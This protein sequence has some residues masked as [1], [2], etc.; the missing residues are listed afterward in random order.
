MSKLTYGP[1]PSRRFGLSLGVDVVP[2]KACTLDCIYCQLG[3]T[4]QLTVERRSF[5]PPEEVVSEVVAAVE[6]G[7]RPDI[8]SFAGSG[9]PTLYQDLGTVARSLREQ[10]GIKLN[11]ITNGTLLWRDDVARDA[12]WFD[13]VAPDLDAADLETFSRI[14]RPHPSLDLEQVLDGI[15]RFSHRHPDKVR[16]EVF[17]VPG[18]ND[19]P[20]ALEAIAKAARRIS[21][22]VVELN[23]AVRP[24]PGRNVAGLGPKDLER[25][26]MLFEPPAVP[27]ASFSS[28]QGGATGAGPSISTVPALA[29]RIL[30]TLRRRPC[31]ARQLAASLGEPLESVQAAS[32]ELLAAHQ[33]REEARGEETY[34]VA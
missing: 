17:L 10:L 26:A 22:A 27:V 14:N 7:P 25:I 32:R 30:D 1:V 6:R 33:V 2:F 23:T 28:A 3:P 12:A 4:D 11:L 9:E 13:I 31:T 24:T 34:L 21:P 5:V 16:L 15:A 20:T 19:T 8:I 18:V 29:V